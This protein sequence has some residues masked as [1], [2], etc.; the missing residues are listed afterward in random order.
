[1]TG[2][3]MGSGDFVG[4]GD[5]LQVVVKPQGC[6]SSSCMQALI[7]SCSVT[8][9]GPTFDVS[10]E[11]CYE[12]LDEPCSKDCGAGKQ[13]ICRSEGPLAEGE[14]TVRLGDL[15]VTFTVPSILSPN[16]QCA[17]I[18]RDP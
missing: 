4:V 1:M 5:W 6:F 18:D 9:H 8:G 16:A 17:S 13:A 12:N 3:P 11:F 2:L 14:Y 7:A 10:A 15:S